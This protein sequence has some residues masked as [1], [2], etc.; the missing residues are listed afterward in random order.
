M[1]AGATIWQFMTLALRA[2]AGLA[3]AAAA[4]QSQ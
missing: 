1:F 3:F 2:A 4:Y